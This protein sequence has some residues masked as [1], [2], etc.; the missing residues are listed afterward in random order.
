MTMMATIL[1]VGL[2]SYALRLVPL[3]LV[4]RVKLSPRAEELL[5]HAVLAAMTALLVTAV[6]HMGAR[7]IPG[8]TPAAA[9]IA[10]AAGTVAAAMRQSMGRVMVIGMAAYAVTSVLAAAV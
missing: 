2:G 5:G 7:P 10:M 6:L 3:L 1:L 8:V 9:W 4:D